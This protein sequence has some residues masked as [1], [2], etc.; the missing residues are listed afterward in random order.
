MRGAAWLHVPYPIALVLVGLAAGAVPGV[1]EVRVDPDVVF[2]VFLPPLLAS[3]GFYSSP[4]E[5]RAELRPLTFL[6]VGLVLATMGG[7]RGRRPRADRRPV[8]AGRVRARRGRRADRPGGGDGHVQPHARARAGGA[9]GRG[10]GDGQR[11]DRARGLP[12]RARGGDRGLLQRRPRRAWTSSSPPPRASRSGSPPA[13]SRSACCAS[14]TTARSR[15]CCRCCSPTPPTSLAEEA[16]VSGVLAAVVCG[17]YLGWFAHEAF[18]ADTRL[19][20]SAF[21]EVLVFGLNALLFLLLGLQFPAI[22]DDARAG[23]FLRHAAAHGARAR[24]GRGA[25]PARRRVPAVHAHGRRLARAAGD[26]LERHARRDL[27][28]G[29]AVGARDR[30]RPARHPVR[31]GR[32]D[33]SSRSSARAS[34]CPRCCA[35]LRLQGERP[36]T[37]DEAIAR[38]ETAQSA[39]DRLDELEDEGGV[40]E[41]QLRRMRELYRARFRACQA[42]LGGGDQ[43]GAGDV[44]ETRRRY[45]DLRRELI[46]VERGALLGLRNEGKLRPDVQRLIQRDLDLEEARLTRGVGRFDPAPEREGSRS[47]C[48]TSPSTRRPARTPSSPR[49]RRRPRHVRHLRAGARARPRAR[50]RPAPSSCSTS[51]ASPS[52]TPRASAC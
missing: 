28:R 19:S 32:R 14:S 16:H 40:S 34:R 43:D 1:P 4:R 49:P 41:E 31:D 47:G 25:D 12:G 50:G 5:L 18:S 38:L 42:V 22:V 2:L 48:P 44:R 37:P 10:R 30:R 17:L 24:G 8:V 9:A 45:S 21:W 20:A 6:A 39:L 23:G 3:A 35:F 27:A 46:G 13:G 33:R 51:R 7:G 36:W 11:R 52:S 29:R 15:S 26:R